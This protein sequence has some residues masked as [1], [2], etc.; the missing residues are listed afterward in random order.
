MAHFHQSVVR[1][2]GCFSDD[3]VTVESE[4]DGDEI[5]LMAVHVGT[6]VI[7]AEELAGWVRQRT[8]KAVEDDM[9]SEEAEMRELARATRHEQD[10]I[11][12]EM[13]D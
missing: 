11:F 9:E 13:R 2:P 12:G 5:H 7:D 8:V 6:G 4:I 10:A 1:V 3:L